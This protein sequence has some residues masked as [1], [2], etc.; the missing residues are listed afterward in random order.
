MKP[1][2]K[3]EKKVMDCLVVAVR[4]FIRL[5]ETHPS[6]NKDFMDGIHKCQ[7]VIIHRIVQRDYPKEFPVYRKNKC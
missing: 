7:D 3:R 4:E 5:E 6:H 2:I 1:Y